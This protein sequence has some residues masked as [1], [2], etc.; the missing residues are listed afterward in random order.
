MHYGN[1]ELFNVSVSYNNKLNICCKLTNES[2]FDINETIEVYLNIP[3]YHKLLPVKQFI[4]YKKV[5]ISKNSS[6]E[7][8]FDLDLTEFIPSD[9]DLDALITIEVGTS[10]NDTIKKQ[11]KLRG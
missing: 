10:S 5:D 6:L 7:I 1:V 11:I 3:Y 2:I 9:L 8:S 4:G